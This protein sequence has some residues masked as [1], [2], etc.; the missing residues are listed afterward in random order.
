[1]I[2]S[3]IK[4]L[5][6]AIAALVAGSALIVAAGAWRLS[7]GPVSL[8]FLSGYLQEALSYS[9]ADGFA[10]TLDDT[11]LTWAGLDRGLDIRVVGVTLFDADGTAAAGIPEMAVGLDGRQL[12]RG[13]LV[14]R[15]VD[16]LS[17][18]LHLVRNLDGS[19][20]LG[21]GAAADDVTGTRLIGRLGQQLLLPPDSSRP[22][23]MLERLSI[24]GARVTFQDVGSGRL[25]IF[26]RAEAD[27]R[28]HEFGIDGNVD[29]ELALGAKRF[30]FLADAA[31]DYV[32]QS[33]EVGLRFND[34]V[35]AD[36]A[37]AAE[38]LRILET[39]QMPL[40]GTANLVIAP[41]GSLSPLNFTIEGGSGRIVLA[42]F[43]DEPLALS[44][45]FAKGVVPPTLDSVTLTD[46]RAR[47]NG[48]RGEGSG[49]ILLE[50]GEPV[51]NLS[52]IIK[53]VSAQLVDRYWPAGVT[54]FARAWF[55][56][57]VTG[58]TLTQG[59]VRLALRGSDIE[60]R[61][62][63]S[64]SVEARFLFSG[65]AGTYL[66]ALPPVTNAAGS[67]HMTESTFEATFDSADVEGLALS[68]GRIR[69]VKEAPRKWN[70]VVEFV[71]SGESK[72]MLGMLDREPLLF[73]TKIGLDPEAIGGLVA[74]R[75][76]IEFPV[77]PGLKPSDV[78]FAAAA[79]LRDTSF[80]D[81]LSG[82]DVTNGSLALQLNAAGL[83][84]AGTAALN[85]VAANV[86]W[87]E[88][89]APGERQPARVTV[90]G[91]F[92]DENR[93][94][95]GFPTGSVIT[96]PVGVEV[97]LLSQDRRILEAT[98]DIDL[99]PARL[100]L[101]PLLW[102]KPPDIEGRLTFRVVPG[103]SDNL[104]AHDIDLRA[105][106]L[107]AMGEVEINA[108]RSLRRLDVSRLQFGGNDLAASVRPQ[109]PDGFI[110]AVDGNA[111]DVGPYL[112][113]FFSSES[114]GN[115]PPVRVSVRLT[116]MVISPTRALHGLSG[117]IIYGADG[118]DSIQMVGTLNEVAPL[119]VVMSTDPERR[120]RLAV[121]TSDA[122]ALARTTGMFR[123]AEGGTLRLAAE[124]DDR[125]E[126]PVFDGR[127]EVTDIRIN[128]APAMARLLTLASLT[129]ILETLNGEG[130]SFARAD[131]PFS[132]R[133]GV[134]S[135]TDARAF[136]P[137]LGI[138]LEGTIDTPE[139]AIFLYGTLVPAYTINRI[140]GSI[141]L[142]GSLLVGR[143]GEGVFAI[144]YDIKGPV[145]EPVITVNPLTA[146]APGFLRN[147]FS[148][149]RG[150]EGPTPSNEAEPD[151]I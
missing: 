150:A 33:L 54:P 46:L 10:L 115:V 76:R 139:D 87:E 83:S 92:D 21:V 35:P 130:I 121:T 94:A 40:T 144:N 127:I 17:P 52:G 71:A 23:A 14:P 43:L 125:G 60:N 37:A 7:S 91:L 138:T 132:F 143:E 30:V 56:K 146:L 136:G 36:L 90:S 27:F 24:I 81:V 28:R 39:I 18:I 22:T 61:N 51:L 75:A 102:E 93:T 80:E 77:R 1:M 123:E 8:G 59:S 49:E 68:E 113:A 95:L 126:R 97:R 86:T 2:R 20:N 69:L 47:S 44:E 64:G 111:I 106:D 48:A 29:L 84:L 135:V 109:A 78:R 112:D 25:W 98:L 42:P 148:I 32:R 120:R 38:E 122:G 3:A 133:D 89:F 149:F 66:G 96:G 19:L 108:D 145:D 103:A 119:A 63:R 41:D 67:V 85:G 5:L 141:P 131:I 151:G 31:F 16:V 58:G 137:S 53:N 142:I 116:E 65:G 62:L 70:A 107:V 129:G 4:I 13:R 45:L 88:N 134:L 55:K 15:T 110:V 128:N 118:L 101:G 34:I 124:I 79:N 26:P 9:G 105:I 82:I 50:D 117:E 74:A 57:N 104:L 114:I 72:I 99:A 147:F 73:A 12:V 100:D 11:I 6:R 140:L